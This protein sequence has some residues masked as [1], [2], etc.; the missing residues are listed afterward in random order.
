M[1]ERSVI[2]A[3]R[4]YLGIDGGGTKTAFTLCG[5]TGEVMAGCRCGSADYR[6]IG[7]GGVGRLLREGMAK[8]GEAAPFPSDSRL[9]VCIGMPNYGEDAQMDAQVEG[10]VRA[11]FPG[12]T[13]RIVNDSQ[14]GWAG[15]LA[16]EPGINLVS[17][18]GSISF[19]RNAAGETATVGGWSDFFSDEGSCRWLGIKC[20]ELFS[21]ES[22]G[23]LPKGALHRILRERLKLSD[24]R[25][26]IGIVEREYRT[27]RAKIASLQRILGEAAAAG[28]P[29]AEQAYEQAAD[30]LIRIV[31]ATADVHRMRGNVKVACSGGLF[32]RKSRMPGIMKQKMAMEGMV[33][34]DPKYSPDLGAVLL[35]AEPEGQEKVLL[36]GFRSGINGGG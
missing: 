18:T 35:A 34:T 23:R 11:I 36:E 26:I 29:E 32:H 2:T 14:A 3:Q 22:D 31:R 8:L 21:K 17:G 24:D 25:D 15:S 1:R 5:E 7:I 10:Q 33:W 19:G 13:T 4:Y 27:S 30:E 12:E 6:Q 20:L 16:L 9:R 28:D